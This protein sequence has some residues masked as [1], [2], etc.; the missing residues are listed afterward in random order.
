[1]D[2]KGRILLGEV[3]GQILAAKPSAAMMAEEAL[4]DIGVPDTYAARLIYSMI[5][6]GLRGDV[7]A[8]RLIRE[9]NGEAPPA[10]YSDINRFG[11]LT[12]NELLALIEGDSTDNGSNEKPKRKGRARKA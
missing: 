9:L 2:N 6:K 4:A 5:D 1:M 8:A 7:S 12:E 11:D 3:T 10:D